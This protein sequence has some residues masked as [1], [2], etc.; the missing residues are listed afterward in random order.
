MTIVSNVAWFGARRDSHQGR[1]ENYGQI[2]HRHFVH[3]TILGYFPEE[4]DDRF[5]SCLVW[6]T[7]LRQGGA[8]LLGNKNVE[9]GLLKLVRQIEEIIVNVAKI[10]DKGKIILENKFNKNL[11]IYFRVKKKGS[12]ASKD[13]KEFHLVLAW[14]LQRRAWFSVSTIISAR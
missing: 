14:I 5:E 11:Q 12:Q 13:Q 1:S 3:L 7:Q 9:S 2:L 6:R 8:Q 4:N 10:N